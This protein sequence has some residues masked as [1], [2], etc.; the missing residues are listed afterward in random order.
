MASVTALREAIQSRLV[1]TRPAASRTPVRALGLV[2]AVLLTL[3]ATACGGGGD[4]DKASTPDTSAADA[5]TLWAPVDIQGSV[6]KI[7][8][9]YRKKFPTVEVTT[10][11]ETQADLNDRLLVGERPD[12]Y[13][14]TG[15]QVN[16]LGDDGTLPKDTRL[17]GTDAL[18]IAVAPGNPKGFA[19]Y[20]DF[21]LEPL[22]RTGLCKPDVACGRAAAPCSP[23]CT[24]FPRQM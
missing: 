18:V 10:V 7:V 14:G 16:S 1:L 5:F 23:N 3:G 17:I 6:E 20:T 9:S 22:T 11:Y 4:D 15:P 24:S 12:L 19:D 2:L 13:I 21:G 8:K